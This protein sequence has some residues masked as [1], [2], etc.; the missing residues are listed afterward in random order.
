VKSQ[1]GKP[2]LSVAD[3]P[4]LLFW[5]LV[6]AS[7]LLG[8]N[9]ISH[10]EKP[11]G[12]EGVHSFQIVMFVKGT[13]KIYQYV[14]MIPVYHALNAALVKIA[15]GAE[16]EYLQK[17]NYLR[18][19]NL[20]LGISVIPAFLSL[21]KYFY[22]SQA[23]SR[24][25]QFIF[26]PFLFPLF[27]LIYTDLLS[28]ALTLFMIERTLSRSYK[29]AALFAFCA[30]FVR[31]PNL[32]WVGYC[33]LIVLLREEKFSISLDFVLSY[34]KKVWPFTIVIGLFAV[35]VVVNGGVAVGDAE[36]HQV[37]FNPSNFYFFLLVGFLLFLPYHVAKLPAIFELLKANLWVVALLVAAFFFYMYTYEHPH[38]YNTKAL[39]FYRH[40][41]F[42]YYSCDVYW[43]RI[44]S[45]FGMAWMALSVCATAR[46]SKDAI[47]II[48]L[49]PVTMLA[50][51]PMPLIEQRY[52][53]VSLSL[54]LAMQCPL[55]EKVTAITLTYYIGFGAYIL[56]NISRMTFFL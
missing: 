53:F 5:A 15:V 20:L 32:I 54:F 18:F 46:E 34:L 7:L 11:I 56:Y 33:G 1:T 12:D 3:S 55:P 45:Y 2:T 28:L 39:D 17:L 9:I 4:R 13:Y 31:Q 23:Y 50:I 42:I 14:T 43:L 22:S 26:I 25:L 6:A 48:L 44:L 38:K 10:M 41:L 27:F 40:N 37:S 30:V 47:P 51:I 21:A 36:Q 19:A 29:L 24:T 8:F 52:Y 35:F 16:L 49:L